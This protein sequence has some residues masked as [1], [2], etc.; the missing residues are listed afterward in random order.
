MNDSASKTRNPLRELNL[1]LMTSL[2]CLLFAALAFAGPTPDAAPSRDYICTDNGG[3]VVDPTPDGRS[4][5]V[6][7][8]EFG[9]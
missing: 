6:G 4:S 1:A 3:C 9:G 8:T 2:V 5:G 7:H